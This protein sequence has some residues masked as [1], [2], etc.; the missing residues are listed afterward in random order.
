M[1]YALTTTCER[2]DVISEPVSKLASTPL[3]RRIVVFDKDDLNR[4]IPPPN[5]PPPNVTAITYLIE[6]TLR[7]AANFPTV[8]VRQDWLLG[9]IAVQQ[10]QLFL[11]EL[12][13][14][15]NKPMPPTGPKQWSF[16]LT[17]RQ[18]HLLEAL[19]V[20]APA[21]RS[22]N[23]ARE[24]A[25]TLFFAEIPAIAKSNGIAWPHELEAAVRA[26]VISAGLPLPAAG[27]TAPCIPA[28]RRPDYSV[29]GSVAA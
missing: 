17:A 19:P 13:A 12:F 8:I 26:Y 27:R 7:Q 25:F 15:S 20:A 28:A 18:R 16:K 11:Y 5:D 1:F 10:V 21:E 22:V 3:S 4:L 23:H 9:V 6:E 2:F 24:A 14:E 29:T